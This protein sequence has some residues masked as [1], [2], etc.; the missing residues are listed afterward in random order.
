[1]PSDFGVCSACYEDIILALPA[2][3]EHFHPRFLPHRFFC[4]LSDPF[5]QRAT[6]IF[7]KKPQPEGL[8]QFCQAI[9]SWRTAL[10]HP[11]PSLDPRTKY[12]G[13]WYIAPQVP[14]LT[15][16]ENCYYKYVSLAVFHDKF[17]RDDAQDN[18]QHQMCYFADQYWCMTVPFQF[19]RGR[20][21][22][23]LFE[24][25]AR[26]IITSP[27]CSAEKFTGNTM[28]TVV[29]NPTNDP[30]Q[31][32][33]ACF[34]GFIQ[35]RGFSSHFKQINVRPYEKGC[36]LH[37]RATHYRW[38]FLFLSMAYHY[39]CWAFFKNSLAESKPVG[40]A[41]PDQNSIHA[42][43]NLGNLLSMMSNNLGVGMD[44]DLQRQIREMEMRSLRRTQETNAAASTISHA[45]VMQGYRSALDLI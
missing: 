37:P 13:N 28:Y 34:A 22:W 41:A 27:P 30:F 45:F 9:Q 5:N 18:N 8:S 33:P 25:S 26:I 35:P 42:L 4:D 6:L 12:T 19:A 43:L 40:P 2:V 32:C 38:Y 23:E 21:S 16:C 17:V 24:R 7:S 20:R 10:S 3:T 11:C 1:M 39:G 15:I 44:S 29:E 36:S 14:G 31:I